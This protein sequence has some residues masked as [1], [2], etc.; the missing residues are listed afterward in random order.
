MAS[1]KINNLQPAGA[2]LFNDSEGYLSELTTDELTLTQGGGTPALAVGWAIIAAAAAFKGYR[3]G[4][5]D[6]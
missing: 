3:D 4:K 2:D 5:A 6:R 1:I